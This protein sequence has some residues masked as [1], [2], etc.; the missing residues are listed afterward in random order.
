[1]VKGSTTIDSGPAPAVDALI[2]A[3]GA[4]TDEPCTARYVFQ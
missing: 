4:G 3:V 2:A 1:L